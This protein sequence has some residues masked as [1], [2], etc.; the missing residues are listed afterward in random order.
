[1]PRVTLPSLRAPAA[2]PGPP[3]AP[4]PLARAGARAE[5]LPL[6]ADLDLESERVVGSALFQDAVARLP[7][8][9][10]LQQLLQ[11][12]LVVL[13][14]GPGD[15]EGLREEA[16]DEDQHLRHPAPQVDDG[17]HG[18]QRVGQ[19]RRLL[20]AAGQ[21]LPASEEQQ[22][23]QP[24]PARHRCQRRLVDDGRP[25]AREL[26]S[27]SSGQRSMS[28]SLTARSRTASPRNS[29]RSLWGRD[30]LALDRSWA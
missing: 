5:G 25:A 17:H 13:P 6:E 14:G 12:G 2:R 8:V 29:S 1:M 20:P 9:A 7:L 24:E 3:P 19:D 23:A 11:A 15:R 26:P 28:R 21:L 27:R 30:S 4:P 10:R 18:L 16:V 22:L